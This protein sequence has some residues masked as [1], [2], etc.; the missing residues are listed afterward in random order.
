MSIPLPLAFSTQVR[1]IGGTQAGAAVID[2][3]AAAGTAVPFFFSLLLLVL[4]LL[5]HTHTHIVY[6]RVCMYIIVVYWDVK[7]AARPC[8]PTFE[9]KYEKKTRHVGKNAVE[10]M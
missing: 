3:L 6:E 8:G 10:V 1:R 2:R 5:L 9:N 4:L 7:I